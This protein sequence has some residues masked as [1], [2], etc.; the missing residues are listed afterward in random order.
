MATALFLNAAEQMRLQRFPTHVSR[1]DIA[2][3]FTLSRRD[4]AEVRRLRSDPN[5]LGFAIVLGAIRMLCFAPAR[6]AVV[7]DE[8]L[9]FVAAQLAM[10][11]ELLGYPARTRRGSV[12]RMR[13]SGSVSGCSRA[14]HFPKSVILTCIR[15]YLRYELSYRDLEEMMAERGVSVDHATINR[16]VIKFSPVLAL[17]AR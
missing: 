2:A 16:W 13:A 10:P 9:H 3:F 15:W 14:C 17:R 12:A 8:V 6:S 1:D 11:P 5:R 4:V 7:P